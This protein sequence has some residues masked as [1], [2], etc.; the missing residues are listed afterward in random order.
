MKRRAFVLLLCTM[1]LFGVCACDG[2]DDSAEVLVP[3][4]SLY[5]PLVEQLAEAFTAE[6]G[7]K[8]TV[9]TVSYDDV[10]DLIESGDFENA[11]FIY[12]DSMAAQLEAGTYHGTALFYD[13]DYLIGPSSDPIGIKQLQSKN[14]VDIFRHIATTDAKFV[15]LPRISITTLREQSLWGKGQEEMDA[16]WYVAAPEG[17]MDSLLQYVAQNKAYALVNKQAYDK[18]EKVDGVEILVQAKPGLADF[19]YLLTKNEEFN[20]RES[21]SRHFVNWLGSDAAR[22]IINNFNIEGAES[23]DFVPVATPIPTQQPPTPTDNPET[24]PAPTDES[25]S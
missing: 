8:I 20:N 11:L 25:A 15:Y 5:L 19:Y 22:N 9:D 7:M 24:S 3:K 14:A 4:D 23:T 2:G 16:S 17:T 12:D 10:P 21:I 1:M 18:A 13:T 6:T